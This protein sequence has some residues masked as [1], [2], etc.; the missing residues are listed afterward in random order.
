MPNVSSKQLC[1]TKSKDL[2][3]WKIEGRNIQSYTE[4]LLMDLF[5][6]NPFPSTDRKLSFGVPFQEMKHATMPTKLPKYGKRK[7]Y[8]KDKQI[9]EFM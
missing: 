1:D 2:K 7:Y 4:N 3:R 9:L 5:P 6:A 8:E